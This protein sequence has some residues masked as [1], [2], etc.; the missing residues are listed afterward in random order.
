MIIRQLRNDTMRM[1]KWGYQFR[2]VSCLFFLGSRH[3]IEE[4]LTEPMC[5]ASI[6]KT[7]YHGHKEEHTRCRQLGRRACLHISFARSRFSTCYMKLFK[8][9]PLNQSI[10]LAPDPGWPKLLDRRTGFFLRQRGE[11]QVRLHHL[12][13]WEHLLRLL[14]LDAGVH[15]HI[16]PYAN[17]QPSFLASLGLI[18]KP[19]RGKNSP[20]T[21]LIGVVTFCLSPVCNESTTLST[22]AVFLPVLAG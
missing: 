16:I 1:R 14:A 2:F 15:D 22:S 11:P 20:G 13:L 7:N 6:V 3:S 4:P 9:L 17:R 19:N 21:Q 10:R 12:H 18:P 5:L 8:L